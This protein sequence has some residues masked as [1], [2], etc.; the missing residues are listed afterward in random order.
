MF[1]SNS[2]YPFPCDETLCPHVNVDH[3]LVS[4]V[5]LAKHFSIDTIP[6]PTIPRLAFLLN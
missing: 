4:E 6:G 2:T 3:E 5:E 1:S